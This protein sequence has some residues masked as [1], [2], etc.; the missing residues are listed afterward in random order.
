MVPSRLSILSR[1]RKKA[2]KRKLSQKRENER[3]ENPLK[4]NLVLFTRIAIFIF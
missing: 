3:E 4:K 1:E 2:I